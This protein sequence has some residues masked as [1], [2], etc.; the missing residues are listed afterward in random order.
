[1]WHVTPSTSDT[2]H[3]WK[4]AVYTCHKRQMK[5]DTSVK[6][7]PTQLTSEIRHKWHVTPVT[8]GMWHLSQGT[9]ETLL[10]NLLACDSIQRR[11]ILIA[12]SW[13]NLARM[14]TEPYFVKQVSEP[15]PH[16]TPVSVHVTHRR[17]PSFIDCLGAGH[18]RGE[19]LGA[20]HMRGE[21]LGA[22][23]RRGE[24]LG[25]G[26]RRGECGV[27]LL[28]FLVRIEVRWEWGS[29]NGHCPSPYSLP[30]PRLHLLAVQNP[31]KE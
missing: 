13:Q 7:H 24:W 29:V 10:Y 2:C 4:I 20:V 27:R 9:S 18:R 26:H 22:G 6:W 30:S 21:C 17:P 8:S 16:N 23:H 12:N 25:A 14:E 11:T 31:R 28:L 5:A 3:K 19:W 1:M 15:L